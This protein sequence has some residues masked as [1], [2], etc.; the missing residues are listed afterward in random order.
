MRRARMFFYVCAGLACL[1][2]AYQVGASR[3]IAQVGG[4]IEGAGFSTYP[5]LEVTF[6]SG[7]VLYWSQSSNGTTWLMPARVGAGGQ[8]V[9]GTAPIVA[10]KYGFVLLANGDLYQDI[11]SWSYL[12]NLLSGAPIAI[13]RQ[14]FGQLKV[15]Y[16]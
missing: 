6:C 11:G 3:A 14:T 9:P 2:A 1:A 8:P 4:A 15:R 12:G 13:P 16:R 7:R 5:F 10:S